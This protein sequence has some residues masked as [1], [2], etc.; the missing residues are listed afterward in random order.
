MECR[1]LLCQAGLEGAPVSARIPF[2]VGLWAACHLR[3]VSGPWAVV[4]QDHHLSVTHKTSLSQCSD[5]CA[6]SSVWVYPLGS[7]ITEAAQEHQVP[8]KTSYSWGCGSGPVP[9]ARGGL[10]PPGASCAL[11][12]WQGTGKKRISFM[13]FSPLMLKKETSLELQIILA[14]M[15]TGN[16]I[17]FNFSAPV[18]IAGVL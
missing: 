3:E 6:P 11:G 14:L 1:L 17:C 16:Q 7:V 9:E 8:L 18:T 13:L 5:E 10:L 4:G 15:G 2:P 12:Q